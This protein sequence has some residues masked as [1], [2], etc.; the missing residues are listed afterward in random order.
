MRLPVITVRFEPER[1]C[2]Q[3][4]RRTYCEHKIG[5]CASCFA[6]FIT[7]FEARAKLKFKDA[8]RLAIAGIRALVEEQPTRWVQ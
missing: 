7:F 3:C 2:K 1:K 4:G 6:T 5:L 8:V